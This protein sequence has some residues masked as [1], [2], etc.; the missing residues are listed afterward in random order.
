MKLEQLKKFKQSGEKIT[1]LTAYDYSF[2]RLF[3]ACGID[4]ILVG[5]SLGNVIQGGE[6]TLNVSM[7]DMVYHTHSVAKACQKSLLI[8]DLPYHSYQTPKQALENAKRLIDQG[9]DMIKLEGACGFEAHFANLNQA[10]IAVCGHLG[11]QP[12]SVLEMGGYRVQGKDTQ[13]A[14]RI[15]T[16]AQLL[17]S[18]G[19]QALVLECIPS[20]LGKKISQKLSVP[21]IGIGA[22]VDCDGQVLVSYDM[23]GINTGYLPKFVHNFL[24]ESKDIPS[25]VSAFKTAV[26]QGVFPNK[27]NSYI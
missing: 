13:G 18:W 6:N 7:E 22:G 11:L 5:D 12:Q 21:T 16:D 27:S 25:A 1:C 19:A 24:L 4:I 10:D 8:A 20:E 15:L 9:A 26:K 23:L 14:Q 17:E 3:D 2:A